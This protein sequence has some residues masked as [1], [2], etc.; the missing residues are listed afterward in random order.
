MSWRLDLGDVVL[1]L[2][3]T[4]KTRGRVVWH[5][6]PPR[7]SRPDQRVPGLSTPRTTPPRKDLIMDLQADKQQEI[8]APDLT[9]EMGNAVPT[10][11]GTTYVYAVDRGDLVNL[12]DNGD[13]TGM[14]AAVGPLG[15]AILH[16][17]AT[18]PMSDGGTRVFTGD[19]LISVVA[20]DVDRVSINFGAVSEVTPDNA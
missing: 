11:D 6:G 18:V 2:S 12:T 8:V 1:D 13:G 20:G 9:D 10:P 14:V 7:R 15:N 3:A 4:A 16:L 5:F 19:A 17:D